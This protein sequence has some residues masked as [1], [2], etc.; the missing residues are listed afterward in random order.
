MKVKLIW[1]IPFLSSNFL[2]YNLFFLHISN[3]KNESRHLCFYKQRKTFLVNSVISI[4][5][6]NKR[7]IL[8]R[9]DWWD[10]ERTVAENK[11]QLIISQYIPKNLR[12]PSYIEFPFSTVLFMLAQPYTYKLSIHLFAYLYDPLS[13]GCPFFSY[14]SLTILLFMWFCLRQVE[15]KYR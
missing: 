3:L 2:T 11:I 15:R 14:L 5:R 10:E 8:L 13:I 9:R 7:I 1:R 12:L 4:L 6:T